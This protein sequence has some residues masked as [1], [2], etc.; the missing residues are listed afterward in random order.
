MPFSMPLPG[1]KKQ[2][3]KTKKGKKKQPKNRNVQGRGTK[4]QELG[5]ACR[6]GK[7]AGLLLR[8]DGLGDEPLLQHST[9]HLPN[10]ASLIK[11]S[12]RGCEMAPVPRR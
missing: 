11:H 10:R 5:N 1:G 7:L 2:Q 6:H 3:N 12:S 9:A 8:G 4:E